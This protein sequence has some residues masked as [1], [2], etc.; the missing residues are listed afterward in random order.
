[1]WWFYPWVWMMES[2]A[3]A[4]IGSRSRF[5]SG[6]SLRLGPSL[7]FIFGVG[8]GVPGGTSSGSS[9]HLV[10]KSELVGKMP[11]LLVLFPCCGVEGTLIISIDKYNEQVEWVGGE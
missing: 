10:R 3:K 7:G 1:M 5:G 4:R 9:A 6:F 2:E 11:P 8:P